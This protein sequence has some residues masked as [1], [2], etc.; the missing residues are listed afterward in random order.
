MTLA[1]W[2]SWYPHYPATSDS[3]TEEVTDPRVFRDV[4]STFCSGITII[5]SVVDSAPVGMTCQSF[6]SVSL[7]PPLV[8]FAASKNSKTFPRL[9]HTSVVSI[10]I[11]SSGQRSVSSAFARSGT[12]KWAGVDWSVGRYGQPLLTGALASLEC[13]VRDVIDA[14]DHHLVVASVLD[15]RVDADQQDPL[16]YFR[17][18]YRALVSDAVSQPPGLD[19]QPT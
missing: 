14:G 19:E 15:L 11:L 5:A 1:A 17:S 13:R 12:D 2:E 10:N 8:A 6:F 4:L 7:D 3:G 18:E 9:R 16:L